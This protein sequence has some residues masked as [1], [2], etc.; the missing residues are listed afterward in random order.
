MRG[1]S[2]TPTTEGDL[3]EVMG[4]FGGVVSVVVRASSDDAY[5]LVEFRDTD[6][7]L[8]VLRHPS[9]LTLHAHTLIVK[10][11]LLKHGTHIKR[12]VSLGRKHCVD[13]AIATA[14]T[15][16]KEF[17]GQDEEKSSERVHM[18]GGVRLT[19]E[20]MSAISTAHSVI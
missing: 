11:R 9:P 20:A 6:T 15:S 5:A 17:R 18:I 3:R 13:V 16:N 4:Q 19:S 14:D 8:A 2:A 10:P 7:A 1:F 12:P